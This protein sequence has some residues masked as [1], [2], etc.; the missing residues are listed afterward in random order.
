M[1]GLVDREHIS[2]FRWC[3]GFSVFSFGKVIYMADFI[4]TGLEILSHVISIAALVAALTP[5]DTDNRVIAQ[6]KAVVD[7]LG[8]N[9][10]NAKNK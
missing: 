6:I 2:G 10:L 5:S 3:Y 4:Q 7:M 8:L 9:I 1:N